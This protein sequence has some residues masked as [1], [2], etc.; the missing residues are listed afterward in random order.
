MIETHIGA[1]DLLFTDMTNR[2]VTPDDG[3]SVNLFYTRSAHF[4]RSPSSAPFEMKGFCFRL[5][6]ILVPPSLVL[7]CLRICSA[8][9][10]FT[11][12]MLGSPPAH[13][14]V[15]FGSILGTPQA[16]IYVDLNS[17]FLLGFIASLSEFFFMLPVI[18][19]H[20]GITPGSILWFLH[21]TLY[22]CT[23]Q[24]ALPFVI[25]GSPLLLVGPCAWLAFAGLLPK[26]IE[27][28]FLMACRAGFHRGPLVRCGVGWAVPGLART[29]VTTADQA[30]TQPR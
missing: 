4:S 27:R 22:L 23:P 30:V 17:T 25:L 3:S 20:V 5:L 29:L 7:W 26:L 12:K 2:I 19:F 1:L 6:I 18:D 8:F 13:I 9:L 21:G 11:L 24:D 10:T 14:L 28:L 15:I 16:F